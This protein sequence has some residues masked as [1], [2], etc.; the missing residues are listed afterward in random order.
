MLRVILEPLIGDVPLVGAVTLFFIRRPV[1]LFTFALH[2][3]EKARVYS[4]VITFSCIVCFICVE[5]G[6]QLDRT[7]KPAGYPRTEVSVQMIYEMMCGPPVGW[8]TLIRCVCLVFALGVF[9]MRSVCLTSRGV[10]SMYKGLRLHC[11]EL[12]HMF[13]RMYYLFSHFNCHTFKRI[14]LLRK[15]DS[16]A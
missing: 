10:F 8:S 16:S 15:T 12:M 13:Q 2:C 11:L 7:Y 14:S 5:T 1:R 9:L 4:Y 6:H 3:Y